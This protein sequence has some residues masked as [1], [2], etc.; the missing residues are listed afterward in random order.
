MDASI[1]CLSWYKVCKYMTES[2]FNTSM[3]YQSP[4]TNFSL[5]HVIARSLLK[6]LDNILLFKNR[7]CHKFSVIAVTETWTD[8]TNEHLV[9]IDGYTKIIKHRMDK[10]V[11]VWRYTLIQIC[12]SHQ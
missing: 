12:H 5:L 7:L 11:V 6:N 1:N 10:K 9:D 2:E 3:K 8:K 4:I